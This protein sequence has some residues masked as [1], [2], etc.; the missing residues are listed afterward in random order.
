MLEAALHDLEAIWTTQSA[1]I[2]EYF[3]EGSSPA[4]ARRRAAA[5]GVTLPDDVV[6]WFA[7]HDGLD[8]NR[9][10]E[11]EMLPAMRPLSLDEA[12]VLARE[13]KAALAPIPEVP[14]ILTGDWL[15][16]LSDDAGELL[17]VSVEAGADPAVRSLELSDPAA[18]QRRF[19]DLTDLARTLTTLF[20]I[21]LYRFEGASV[22]ATDPLAA[23]R[24]IASFRDED[25][26]RSAAAVAG[27]RARAATAESAID[28]EAAARL[29]AQVASFEGGPRAGRLI[30]A[31]DQFGTET[32]VEALRRLEVGAREEAASSLGYTESPKA[33]PLLL[34]LLDDP[35]DYVRETAAGAIGMVGDPSVGPRLIPLLS[36][37]NKNLRKAA[38]FSLGELGAQDA[39]GS[40][41]ALTRDRIPIVRTAAA[42][43]LGKIGAPVDV[44]PLVA[45]LDDSYPEA[46]QMAAW[47][48]G[49]IGDP[50]A[51]GPIEKAT[52]APGHT[53]A[54]IAREALTALRST[55]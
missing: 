45:L 47:A 55:Q 1:P 27:S 23:E 39:V 22:R 13:I 38:A 28:S 9:D 19:D 54:R 21:G 42:T 25:G 7:W 4:S 17:F 18:P 48:L 33:A 6:E 11:V 2:V 52:Q 43:A 31:I 44:G 20:Q 15:P 14:T 49:E 26:A 50:A 5:F 51:I 37:S 32:V 29:A 3:A 30:E 24:F 36:S 41:L 8:A 53:L 40:L 16:L 34:A 12:L 10:R 46:A 35:E